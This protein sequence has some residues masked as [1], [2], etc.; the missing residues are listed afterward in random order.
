MASL[1]ED[2]QQQLSRKIDLDD[3]ASSWENE[4]WP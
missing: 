3:A 4:H 1:I 2:E